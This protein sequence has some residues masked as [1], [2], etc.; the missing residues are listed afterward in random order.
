MDEESEI[1]RIVPT[2]FD[3]LTDGEAA[4][5]RTKRARRFVLE[6]QERMLEVLEENL[7]RVYG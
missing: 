6:R 3:M 5:A 2:V 4:L 7:T 1:P